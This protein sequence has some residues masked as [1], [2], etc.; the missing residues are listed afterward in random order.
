MCEN[1]I[2]ERAKAFTAMTMKTIKIPSDCRDAVKILYPTGGFKKCPF[3]NS[4]LKRQ[5][6]KTTVFQS[7]RFHRPQTRRL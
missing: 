7:G 5:R 3:F 6:S 4:L 1:G 2:H